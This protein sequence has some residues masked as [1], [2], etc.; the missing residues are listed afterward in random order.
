MYRNH[1]C[2]LGSKVFVLPLNMVFRQQPQDQGVSACCKATPGPGE[3]EKG[4][5]PGR[6]EGDESLFAQV[7]WLQQHICLHKSV[8]LHEHMCL[9]KAIELAAVLQ[10]LHCSETPSL[11]FLFHSWSN[12]T[13]PGACLAACPWSL[14]FPLLL[15]SI[16]PGT[17]H[18]FLCSSMGETHPANPQCARGLIPALHPCKSHLARPCELLWA[19]AELLLAFVF[20]CLVINVPR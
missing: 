3:G 5:S 7:H 12:G 14:C 1:R 4:E 2:A 11:C 15:W 13:T 8:A 9:H 16:N 19:L 10:P 6:A 17:V 20:A 18:P